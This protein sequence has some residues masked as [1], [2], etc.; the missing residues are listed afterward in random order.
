MSRRSACSAS[1][2]STSTNGRSP[3][4]PGRKAWRTTVQERTTARPLTGM[5]SYAG[6]VEPHAVHTTSGGRVSVPH[7]PQR[8]TVR[9]CRAVAAQYGAEDLVGHRQRPLRRSRDDALVGQTRRCGPSRSPVRSGSP[10]CARRA[11]APVA[12][13]AAGHRIALG[14]WAIGRTTRRRSRR[15]RCSELA[16]TCG[17]STSS[18]MDWMGDHGASSVA[19]IPF[20]SSSVCSAKIASSSATHAAALVRRAAM[21]TNRPSSARSARS[22]VRQNSGQYLSPCRNINWTWR[23]SFVR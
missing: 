4:K 10:R 9:T 3:S 14:R 6:S 8:A 5:N 20:H 17:S 15:R 11:L 13:R 23:S 22:M 21:S 7:C 18:S 16:I 1:S 12:A 2:T 19:R